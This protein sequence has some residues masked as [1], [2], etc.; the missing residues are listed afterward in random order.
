MKQLLLANFWL[1]F[2]PYFLPVACVLAQ[3]DTVI[4]TNFI[5]SDS[6]HTEVD[7][8]PLFAGCEDILASQSQ[9]ENCSLQK[10]ATFLAQNLTYPDSA[11]IK[12]TA[13]LLLIRF[14]VDSKGEIGK[15]ELLR[16]LGDGCGQEALR[17]LRLMP[18]FSP[19]LKL[20]KKVACY[21]T[22]PVRFR[23]LD[24]PP[25]TQAF[26]LHWGALYG[27]KLNLVELKNLATTP[28]EARDLEGNILKIKDLQISYLYKKRVKTQKVYSAKP[29]QAQQK[30]LLSAKKG[31]ILL[32]ICRVETG[33]N[34]EIVEI[35][36]ELEL[37]D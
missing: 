22:L 36:R 8:Q 3:T 16:D 20:G 4:N 11:K 7:R 10:I 32:L 2:L 31:G 21:I 14:V 34:F 12:K 26:S 23:E 18:N 5:V 30:L 6:I 37:V 1:Y 33:K 27:E 35:T 17:V 29:N 28:V 24:A 25:P 19:A 15:T 13:G 9:Q